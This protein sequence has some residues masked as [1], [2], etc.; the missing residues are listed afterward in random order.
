ML[1]ISG[2]ATIAIACSTAA[3]W[4]T[5]AFSFFT[6][7]NKIPSDE[8]V[9]PRDYA[10]K[11]WFIA[12][13]PMMIISSFELLL[14]NI[15]IFMISKYLSPDQTGIYFAATKIMALIAFLN[16]A[17]GSAFTARYAQYHASNNQKALAEIVKKSATLTL[18][19]CLAMISIILLFRT[20]LLSLFGPGF[21][22]AEIVILILAIGLIFRAAIG[23]GERVLMMTGHQN[24]CAI[25]YLTTASLDVVLNIILIPEYGIL[26]AAIATTISFV[27]MAISLLLTI[28]MRLNILSFAGLPPKNLKL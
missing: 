17:I 10:I 6:I 7:A 27:V 16:Y 1:G 2:D 22:N 24:L 9:G 13:L 19:P 26:G 11:P 5:L 3:I 28:K 25:I 4:L 8:R 20:Q 23:P 21:E 15:D 18:Y 14:F 12:A